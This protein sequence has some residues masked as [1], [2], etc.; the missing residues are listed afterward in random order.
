MKV[1]VENISPT[2]KKLHIQVPP[3][4]IEKEFVAAYRA[5]RQRVK[6]P[7]FR[8]GRVPMSLL[9]RRF[10]RDVEADLVKRLVPEYYMKALQESGFT[11]VN[12]PEIEG[13]DIGRERGLTFTASVEVKPEIED[14]KYEGIKLKRREIEVTEE[15]IKKRLE[16]LQELNAQL[17]VPEE[18]YPIQE[19]DYVLVDYT[20]YKNNKPLPELTKE[21]FF[22][23]VTG[24]VT[25]T[26]LER[27]IMGAKKGDE[28][29]I[30]IKEENILFKVKIKEIKRRVLPEINDDF[31][32]DMGD[33]NT[34]EE[35]KEY[36]KKQIY[37]EKK[38]NLK[39]EYKRD[40]IKQLIE[41]NPIE[42]PSSLVEKETQRLL[43]S[44]KEFS[45]KEKLEPEEE[46]ALKEQYRRYAEEEIKGDLLLMAIGEKENIEASEKDMEEEIEKIAR[47]NNQDI[48]KVRESLEAMDR[49]LQGLKNKVIIDKVIDHIME[50]V[51]WID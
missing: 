37:E 36:L 35:L 14:V 24:G 32:R 26:D 41:W 5:L 7:G 30:P 21:D 16:L 51:E 42:A 40:I 20:G 3:E 11:P 50:K 47:R 43:K 38:E 19:G 17:A 49:G 23:K 13:I 18:D 4:I 46:R 31:A 10:G 22:F 27:G 6:I 39:G 8:P 33:Y 45:G 9:E 12:M 25:A 1:D 2:K 34:L 28:V 48:R 29:E 44:A 15:D